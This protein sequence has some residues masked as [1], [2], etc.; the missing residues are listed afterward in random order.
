MRTVKLTNGYT[1]VVDDEDY[2]P[3]S[4]FKWHA[5][6]RRR[7]DG[8]IRCV[9]AQRSVVVG[10][11]RAT[12]YLHRFVMDAP[13]GLQ[14]DHIDGDGLNNSRA[15]LRVCTNSENQC[16]GRASGGS[17]KYRGVSWDNVC[18]K[19]RAQIMLD[20]KMQYLGRFL[21]EEDAARAYD[22]AAL[23]N[24]GEFARMNF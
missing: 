3:V 21:K 6:V 18:A 15:N 20:G 17:S 22:V 24:F 5:D 23:D 1:A 14:V 8:R 11:K 7:R 4:A 16:N 13:A 9:Y 19:W 2:G 10:G 12:Q